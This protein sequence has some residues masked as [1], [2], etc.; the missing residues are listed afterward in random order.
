MRM[1][2]KMKIIL[3]TSVF[4]IVFNTKCIKVWCQEKGEIINKIVTSMTLKE[5]A[6]LVVGTGM[7]FELPDSLA[8][9][10]SA[11][12]T[13]SNETDPS[14]SEMVNRIRKY[15]PGAAGNTA[16]F[17][18]L[19]SPLK[20]LQ[21]VL[22]VCAYN[23]DGKEKRKCILHCFPGCNPACSSPGIQVW[24]MRLEKPWETKY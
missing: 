16:E 20:F 15:V 9:L 11:V 18:H 10:G 5:K 24:Y 2:M 19:E 13:P 6:Q 12:N 7:H 8:S 21:M 14:Y 22:P 17:P 23:P 3:I 4:L 1:K